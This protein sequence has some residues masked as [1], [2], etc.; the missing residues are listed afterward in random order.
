MHE[1]PSPG[2]LWKGCTRGMACSNL[3]YAV[4]PQRAGTRCMQREEPTPADLGDWPSPG[5]WACTDG[6]ATADPTVLAGR[7]T[8]GEA[9]AG[10]RPQMASWSVP[11]P[12]R[13]CTPLKCPRSVETNEQACVECLSGNASA[14]AKDLCRS[15][16]LIVPPGGCVEG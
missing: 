8:E 6:T 15:F 2:L 13:T 5:A 16:S 1:V 14:S 7:T 9:G 11:T 3:A 12:F 4:L 10:T